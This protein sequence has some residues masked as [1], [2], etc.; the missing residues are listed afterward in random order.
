MNFANQDSWECD[1]AGRLVG[2]EIADR[3][4]R[5]AT[6]QEIVIGK[7]VL[8]DCTIETTRARS[9]LAWYRSRLKR[10]SF[11]GRYEKS[12]FGRRLSEDDYAGQVLDC[13]F[14]LASLHE[15]LF[16]DVAEGH[17]KF[18][19]WPTVVARM[20]QATA[21][22]LRADWPASLYSGSSSLRSPLRSSEI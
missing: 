14:S 4:V 1:S 11:I 18:A 8:T 12:T 20:P 5:L 17:I 10:C 6:D 9:D 19:P 22:T 7:A 16:C 3:H 21:A 13:D 15:C 2:V